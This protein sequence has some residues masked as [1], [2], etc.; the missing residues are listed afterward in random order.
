MALIFKYE[1]K[2]LKIRLTNILKASFYIINIS[3]TLSFLK[4][5]QV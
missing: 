3:G 1:S 4:K 5:K 2:S